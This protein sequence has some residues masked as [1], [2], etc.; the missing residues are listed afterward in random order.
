MALLFAAV[1][2]D[3]PDLSTL[4][5][6][7]QGGVFGD[8]RD[9]FAQRWT[10]PHVQRK[11]TTSS[12]SYLPILA[13]VLHPSHR[14]RR[15][16][17][18]MAIYEGNLPLM[19][20]IVACQPWLLTPDAFVCAVRHE[21]LALA[22]YLQHAAID[23]PPNC[24]ATM[25]N[26]RWDVVPI[27][28]VDFAAHRNNLDLLVFLHLHGV[29]GCT[30]S[31]F[32][33]AASHGNVA[34]LQFLHKEY[35]GALSP[36][37]NGF[38]RAI[39]HGHLPALQFLVAHY[40]LQGVDA[41]LA[42][43]Y[44]GEGGDLAMATYVATVLF[45][46]QPTA[47]LA[48]AA[49]IHGHVQLLDWLL[50]HKHERGSLDYWERVVARGHVHVLE[51]IVRVHRSPMSIGQWLATFV[52]EVLAD[53]V[54]STCYGYNCHRAGVVRHPIRVA[55]PE[56]V[57]LLHRIGHPLDLLRPTNVAV[58][59]TLH[60]RGVQFTLEH[61]HVA[62]GATHSFTTKSWRCRR[63][64]SR[65]WRW[66]NIYSRGHVEVVQFVLDW[67]VKTETCTTNAM[68]A[69]IRH[70]HLEVVQFLHQKNRT[71]SPHA[72]DLAIRSGR[73]EMVQFVH[74]TLGPK[75][76][77]NVRGT[78][79]PV[80]IFEY[81]VATEPTCGTNVDDGAL[82][83]HA[84]QL[85]CVNLVERIATRGKLTAKDVDTALH[86]AIQSGSVHLVDSLLDSS[87]VL[88]KGATAMA[89][90]AASLLRCIDQ[91]CAISGPWQSIRY[92]LEGLTANGGHDG[93]TS[94]LDNA[95]GGYLAAYIIL[96]DTCP[97]KKGATVM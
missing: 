82:L 51:W 94:L 29:G 80:D 67:M 10:T 81:F 91:M 54:A 45:P 33:S 18:H 5:F 70:G 86:V 64:A 95:C 63:S 40:P 49:A 97:E 34:M 79:A 96:P 28:L 12:P 55:K 93:V 30:T 48:L 89:E 2:F 35:A 20:R 76:E 37:A 1:V 46:S 50:I 17:L 68:D 58:A 11:P 19:Q 36:S 62:V 38:A 13:L 41:K 83:L 85:G 9:R 27:G 4:I 57:A 66:W 25:T 21:H 78:V 71:C 69:A 47:G 32:D 14:D 52:Y 84:V 53:I 88:F 75:L 77:W 31:A 59:T 8:L 90:Q 26:P 65:C 6:A 92:R 3:V 43:A 73:L 87:A 23:H 44:A 72:L 60:L 7:F 16:A 22:R 42:F 74:K 61:V 24:P 15:F 39:Q 56:L